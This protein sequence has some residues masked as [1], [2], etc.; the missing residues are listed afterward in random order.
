MRFLFM[1]LIVSILCV[2][3]PPAVAAQVVATVK[4]LP[5]PRG[6]YGI[7]RIAYHWVDSSRREQFSKVP[8]SRRE[9]MVY[10]WYPADNRERPAH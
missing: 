2:G 4:H 5:Q 7:G 8:G 6:K 1:S 10:I 9:L 3:E